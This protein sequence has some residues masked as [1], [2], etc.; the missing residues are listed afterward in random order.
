MFKTFPDFKSIK[1]FEKYDQNTVSKT[2]GWSAIE[3]KLPHSWLISEGESVSIAFIC[4]GGSD[5]FDINPCKILE[6]KSDKSLYYINPVNC[7]QTIKTKEADSDIDNSGKSSLDIGIICSQNPQTGMVGI[8]PRAQILPIN[9]AKE[10]GEVSE[11]SFIEAMD[12]CIQKK[13]DIVITNLYSTQFSQAID[14]KILRLK[15]ENIPF[16]CSAGMFDESEIFFPASSKHAITTGTYNKE[17]DLINYKPTSSAPSPVASTFKDNSYCEYS[18]LSTSCPFITSIISLLLAKNKKVIK[19][20]GQSQIKK[21]ED[22]INVL[23]NSGFEDLKFGAEGEETFGI[24]NIENFLNN[25]NTN[26]LKKIKQ[27]E[28]EEREQEKEQEQEQEQELS[29]DKPEEV[30]KIK[31]WFKK[32]FK[33]VNVF[34]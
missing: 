13:P 8:A 30:N 10:N 4:H 16:I 5:H 18:S 32:I 28:K 25:I 29:R 12:Y 24:V 3:S 15:N 1:T 34:K 6:W 9:V 17:G 20:C 14:D 27:E 22:I 2:I 7:I 21:T 31:S 26:K 23:I 19:I 11:S 33:K